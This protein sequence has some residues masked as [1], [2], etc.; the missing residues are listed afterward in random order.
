MT[1]YLDELEDDYLIVTANGLCSAQIICKQCNQNIKQSCPHNADIHNC[2]NCFSQLNNRAVCDKCNCIFTFHQAQ[3]LF[4][5]IQER[6]KA[7]ATPVDIDN[8]QINWL[9]NGANLKTNWWLFSP[10]TNIKMEQLYQKYLTEDSYDLHDPQNIF[11]IN[12]KQFRFDFD[13]MYQ[14]NNKGAVRGIRR[15]VD[16]DFNTVIG[17]AGQKF[18]KKN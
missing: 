4:K 5:A 15:L 6:F 12:G 3:Q 11:T 14:S 9:Y 7:V 17:M 10:E 13:N 18:A 16:L 8:K 1:D 2:Y